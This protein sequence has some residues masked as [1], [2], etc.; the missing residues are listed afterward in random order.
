[1]KSKSSFTL[2]SL[3]LAI[4]I[5]VN[6]CTR[7]TGQPTRPATGSSGT[8]SAFL[9]DAPA[10]GVVAFSIQVTGVSLVGSNGISTSI[11]RGIQEIEMRH[12]QLAP[13]LAF[14]GNVP[15]GT[16]TALNMEFANP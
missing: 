7:V 13:T 14:Q 15:P 4:I 5:G 16:F 10:D 8:V 11:S 9:T 1:M 3:V 12:L 2:C 6:G